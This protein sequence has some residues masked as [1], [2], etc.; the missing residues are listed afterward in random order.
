[1]DYS[2]NPTKI[3][4]PAASM[5]TTADT[6]LMTGPYTVSLNGSSNAYPWMTTT[7]TSDTFTLD[8]NWTNRTS[9]KIQLNGP[10]A[11]IEINGESLV[12]SIR[13]IEKRLNML[14][15]NPKLEADWAEL[16]ALGDQYRKLEKHILDKMKTWEKISK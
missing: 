9:T 11:D 14:T 1:M 12:K 4:L 6:L 16:K 7:Q 2:K 15:V 8:P 3:T 5:S 13:A 10:E